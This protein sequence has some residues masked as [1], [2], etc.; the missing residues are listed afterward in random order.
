MRMLITE[1]QV[2]D[3]IKILEEDDTPSYMKDV[4]V[5]PQLNALMNMMGGNG[6]DKMINNLGPKGVESL[7][8]FFGVDE[9]SD[10]NTSNIEG[11]PVSGTES[12]GELMHPLGNSNFKVGSGFAEFRGSRQHKGVDLPAQSGTPVYAP[13][14]GTVITAR[15]TTPNPCGGYIQ[16]DHGNLIT[17]FCHLSKWSVTN[18]QEIKKGQII[19]YTGGGP[20]DP[21]RGDSSGPHLHYQI[22]DKRGLAINPQQSQFGLA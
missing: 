7:K 8:K 17:K 3:L 2:K 5:P 22:L 1:N 13:A 10:I 20:N 16:L 15:D 9:L 6:L 4:P 19:G 21:Y 12:S 11:S 18:G 14:N